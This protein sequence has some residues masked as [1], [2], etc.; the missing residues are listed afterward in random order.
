MLASLSKGKIELGGGA[1]G[2]SLPT[3]REITF[4]LNDKIKSYVA[5]AEKN[6]DKLVGADT[7]VVRLIYRMSSL[8]HSLVVF[9]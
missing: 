5:D 4:E 8:C 2:K 9:L 1:S 6:F 3:P 7:L